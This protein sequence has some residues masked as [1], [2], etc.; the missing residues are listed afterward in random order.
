M[1]KLFFCI[2]FCMACFQAPAYR[3]DPPQ[4]IKTCG[5]V[6]S[7]QNF[8]EGKLSDYWAQELIGADLLR[9]EAEKIPPPPQANFISIFDD[10]RSH[11]YRVQN[12]ISS[13]SPYALLPELGDKISLF[14]ARYV[15][16]YSFASARLK[17]RGLPFFINNSMTWHPPHA[18][19]DI[20]QSYEEGY[21]IY[22]TFKELSSQAVLV[23]TS[24][25]KF[26][27]PL[28]SLKSKAS[29]DFNAIIVGSFSPY[30]F[31]SGFSQEGEEL[32]ILAPSDSFLASD[33]GSYISQFS[34]TSGAAPLVT[35][36]LAGFEWIAG[37]HPTGEEAKILLE[38]TAIPTLHSHESP[39]QNGAGLLNAYKLARLAVRLKALC[40]T[41][42]CFQQ[43]IRSSASWQFPKDEA[44]R[45]DVAHAFP[46][47]AFSNSGDVKNLS[48]PYHQILPAGK[49]ERESLYHQAFFRHFGK[50]ACYKK[51]EIFDRL[52]RELLLSPNRPELWESLSCIY[53]EAGFEQNAL[54]LDRLALALLP[55]E[56]ALSR[57]LL[58]FEEFGAAELL[59][60]ARL[61][62]N[63]GGPQALIL[64]GQ[65]AEDEDPFVKQA[66]VRALIG[67]REKSEGGEEVLSILAQ[68]SQD[69]DP[70]V[71]EAVAKALEE[72]KEGN[73]VLPVLGQM[74]EDKNPHVRQAVVESLGKI[75]GEEDAPLLGSRFEDEEPLIRRMVAHYLGQIGGEA[76]LAVL[77]R[78]IEDEDPL[79]RWSV[80]KSLEKVKW[81][82]AF[83]LLD[84]LLEDKNFLV[85]E[86]V[87]QTLGQFGEEEK[88]LP[89]L[90]REVE[91]E[92]PF[93]QEAA[94]NA[95]EHIAKNN[96]SSLARL[97]LQ[98][99]SLY[100][101]YGSGATRRA[102]RD[103]GRYGE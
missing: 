37:Y 30:G 19:S 23:T 12:L 94:F 67:L 58:L 77:G 92:D 89:L 41:E 73:D 16:E 72:I 39:R 102:K 100:E 62:G 68:M 3:L 44:L 6:S 87:V 59:A 8:M 17:A 49:D 25:N 33:S 36:A 57:L 95:I 99:R 65:A 91:N 66:V 35:G 2:A 15:R 98:S 10:S 48:L 61:A 5:I 97:W 42:E 20:S 56:E 11:A 83:P 28:Y 47:C 13:S 31:V 51:R 18:Y 14:R 52:R 43:E 81:E 46:A 82:E 63:I 71:R 55:T 21:K 22:N 78:M 50:D 27:T 69:E 45:A 7:E 103:Q 79:V 90:I 70:V 64:L 76:A 74:I 1:K 80:A 88:V 9:K 96:E 101:D 54:M 29:K 86:A 93:V 40:D 75:I 84:R 32:H 4:D 34:G 53:R 85:R 38:K 24:G 26:P 60:I